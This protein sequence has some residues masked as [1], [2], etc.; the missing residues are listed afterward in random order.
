MKILIYCLA[1]VA[2]ACLCVRAFY[3]WL[4]R[5]TIRTVAGNL[6]LSLPRG[7]EE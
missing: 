4:W 2:L 3:S 6:K 7:D 1:S 5:D